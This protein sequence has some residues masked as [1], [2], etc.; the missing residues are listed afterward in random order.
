MNGSSKLKLKLMRLLKISKRIIERKLIIS[1][2]RSKN[3]WDNSVLWDKNKH[4]NNVS[5]KDKDNKLELD[6]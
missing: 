1:I 4:K 5:L 2:W 6:N 3:N